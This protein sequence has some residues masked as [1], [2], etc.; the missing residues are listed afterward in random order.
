MRKRVRIE[1]N[2]HNVKPLHHTA[3]QMESLY[4]RRLRDICLGSGSE[5]T[6]IGRV[7][8]SRGSRD[9]VRDREVG[10]GGG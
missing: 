9:S 5:N 3:V 4:F 1:K 7:L 2:R 8:P 6:S 10:G